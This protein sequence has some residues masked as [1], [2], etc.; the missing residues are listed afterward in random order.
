MEN[1]TA[2]PGELVWRVEIPKLQ[3]ADIFRAY[4]I[5][6]RFDQ[7]I[8]A[9]MAA[10]KFTPDGDHIRAARIAFGGMAATPKRAAL[11][12]HAVTNLQLSKPESWEAAIAA[13][14]QDYAPISDMRAS[15]NYRVEVAQSLLRKALIEI[16]GDN[17]VTRIVG[18]RGEA[19]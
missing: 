7:D 17:T 15:A 16:A 1:K 3:R 13:L 9:V 18:Q 6:K 12:E 5:S 14:A 10:F 4:K 8:S 2:K 19:A 11:A